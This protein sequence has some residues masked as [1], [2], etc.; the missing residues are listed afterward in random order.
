MNNSLNI[1]MLLHPVIMTIIGLIL[2]PLVVFLGWHT[3]LGY[4]LDIIQ[5]IQGTPTSFLMTLTKSS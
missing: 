3:W 5:A 2:G 1:G 4:V